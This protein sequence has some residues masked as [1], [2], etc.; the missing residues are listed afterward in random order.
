MR[1]TALSLALLATASTALAEIP[2]A[3]PDWISG[4]W[5][6]CE[7][8]AQIA[9][10]W[11]G[12]GTGTLLGTNLTQGERSSFEF[13]RVAVN[14]RGG[15]SY[16]SMPNGAPVTEFILKSNEKQRVEF[17]NLAH[18]FP[19]RIIYRRDGSRLHARIEGEING[20]LESREWAFELSQ[21]D[22]KCPG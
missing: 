20:Q 19:Q 7:N 10:H 18:D 9:E 22:Q 17:E 13:L 12:A 14:G 8:G 4:H 3:T 1:T 6:A 16:Y 5:L 15:I 21:P 11:F 2:P